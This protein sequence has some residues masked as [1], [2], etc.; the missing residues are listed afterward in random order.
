MTSGGH[1]LLGGARVAAFD[2]IAAGEARWDLALPGGSSADPSS[3]QLL[4]AGSAVL[5]AIALARRGLRVGL[6]AVLGD[7]TPGRALRAHVAAA[8]VDIGG[9]SLS[10]PQ[11]SLLFVEGRGAAAR[12]VSR[13]PEEPPVTIPE[14]W[15]AQ[16]LLLTGLSPLVAHAGAFCKEARRARRAGTV[17]VL[18]LR[19]RRHL[20]AGHDPRVLRSVLLECDV[21]RYSTDDMTVLGLDPA[22]A[23]AMMRPEAVLVVTSPTRIHATGTFGELTS[24]RPIASALAPSSST[25]ESSPPA[26]GVITAICAELSRSGPT[27]T[28][29]PELWRRVVTRARPGALAPSPARA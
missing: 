1:M 20:W 3:P 17:V 4:P 11:P 28:D 19:A 26:G 22:A 14:G 13:G 18:D 8:G 25:P 24:D 16:V 15:A 5:A 27:G 7:D 21:V 29:L 12:V 9:V 2:V 23:R 10:A 6:A